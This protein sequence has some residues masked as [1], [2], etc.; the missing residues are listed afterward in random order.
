MWLPDND[1]LGG[2][3]ACPQGY[4]Q[5]PGIEGGPFGST[6]TGSGQR[7]AEILKSE[8]G[9]SGGF[10]QCLGRREEPGTFEQIVGGF[11][12]LCRRDEDRPFVPLQHLQP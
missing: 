1:L 8:S 5:I 11:L 4:P 6:K 7:K 12:R 3:S 10:R 9:R 2:L